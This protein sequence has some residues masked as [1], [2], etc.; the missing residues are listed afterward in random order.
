MY[1]FYRYS[2]FFLVLISLLS[3]KEKSKNYIPVSRTDFQIKHNGKAIDLYTL[4]NSQGMK[5]QI[6]NYG[7]KVVS[8]L[9]P[10]RN[11]ELGDVSLGYETASEYLN[12][13]ASLGATMGRYANR[14]A[15]AQFT[16]NDSTYYLDKNNGEN[17]IHGGDEG[18]RYQ[19][20]DAR[21]I[22]DQTLELSYFSEDGEGGYPGNLTVNVIYKVTEENELKLEYSARTDKPTV[23]N[24]TNHTFFNLAGEGKGS[25]LN[26]TLYVN[27]NQYTP[28]NSVAIP[29]GELRDVTGTPFD[30][31]TPTRIGARI[32][33]DNE[34]LKFVGGYD[35]NF[36]LNK[37]PDELA[38]AARLSEPTTGR[39][40]EVY[41]TEPGLQVYTANSLTG[42]GNQ[43]GKGG[44]AYGP[45]SAICLETQHFPDAP[46]HPNF[47]STVLVPGEEYR[48]TTIYKFSVS[49]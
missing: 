47:P 30:F 8:I 7:G 18:F 13:I 25:V 32:D 11:G 28:V 31:T 14:I 20:W 41:T 21:K 46:H 24:L 44:H 9:V 40:M 22:D 35:H 6:T 4:E 49:K 36:V 34:Q 45:R 27:A 29:T 12:G 43:I 39:V 26:H 17:S 33:E 48:S 42:E 3:C 19:V 15:N 37:D 5:V 38:L 10:D 16:L 2:L 1:W 23:I